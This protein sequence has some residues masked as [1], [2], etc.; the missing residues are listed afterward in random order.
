V[1]T[2]ETV[3]PTAADLR[4]IELP[5]HAR[6]DGELIVAESLAAVPYAISRMFTLR[7]P[8]GAKRGVHAHR[9]CSQFMLCV[10][11]V[12]DVV[13]DD[14]RERR[15]FTLD[16][17]N[18]ALLVPPKIWNIVTFQQADSV[19]VVLCDRPYEA[20]DYIRDYEEFLSFRK[21]PPA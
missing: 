1:I 17:G 12:I 13:C 2:G 3:L 8:A 18:L 7:A 20:D 16:R 4:V 5:R 9:L 15:T 11:G 21:A 10:R 14:G 6:A 19:L